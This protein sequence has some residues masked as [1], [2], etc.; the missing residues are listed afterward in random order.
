[1]PLHVMAGVRHTGQENPAA[2]GDRPPTEWRPW[3]GNGSRAERNGKGEIMA[4]TLR[5]LAT[6]LAALLVA[7]QPQARPAEAETNDLAT[8]LPA[9][10][11]IP[12]WKLDGEPLAY[13]AENL[14]EYI[15][16]AAENFLAFGCRGMVAQTYVSEGGKGLKVEIFE[17]S[18]PLMAYGIYAQMRSPGLSFYDIG[19][20][21]FADAFSINFWKDRYFV[22][23][24]AFEKSDAL[25]RALK[26][27]AAA[28]DAKIHK[29][30]SLPPEAGAFAEEGLEPKSLCFL[31]TGVLG[32]EHF[33]PSFVATY[34][35]DEEEAKLYL[36]TLA[37]TTAARDTLDWYISKLDSFKVWPA[38]PNLPY[39]AGTGWDRFQGD[40]LTF[41]YQKWFGVITGL[42]NP[43]E[44]GADLVLKTIEKLKALDADLSKH[45]G[46]DTSRAREAE[47]K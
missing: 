47:R 35:L 41:Q 30:G 1:M 25:S 37:D 20:E 18:S 12:G 5:I 28:V 38:S 42:K 46:V 36:S 4:M 19:N 3:P 11:S 16:G 40:V 34:T 45:A 43:G 23:V 31:T 17:H 10:D 7:A 44:Q 15:D 6:A 26:T 22:R 24:S 21:A 14:W 32:L 13:G 8:L 29:A 39:F 27:F 33:P 2:C 9:P